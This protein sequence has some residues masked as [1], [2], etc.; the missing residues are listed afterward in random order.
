MRGYD[1]IGQGGRTYL[2][3]RRIIAGMPPN[4]VNSCVVKLHALVGSTK[5]KVAAHRVPALAH[6]PRETRGE[7]RGCGV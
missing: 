7:C 4:A 5:Q 6:F 3:S 2:I 1:E